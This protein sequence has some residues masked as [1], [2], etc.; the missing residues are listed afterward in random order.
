MIWIL[1]V[2]ALCH[3]L[4]RAWDVAPLRLLKEQLDHKEWAGFAFYDLIFPL[5]LFIIGVSLVFSL[6][7]ISEAGDRRAAVKRVLVRGALLYL[8]GLFY[9]GGFSRPWPELRLVGV[10]P[11]LAIGYTVAALLF[12]YFKPRTLAAITASLLLGYWALL[13]WV[14]VRDIALDK[15]AMIARFG[16]R[17]TPQQVGAAYDA[18]TATVT[19]RYEPGLNVANHFDFVHLPG[20]KYDVYWDPEGILSTIPAVA[21]CLLGVFAGLLLRRVDLD[22]RQKLARL[23]LAGALALAGGWAWHLEFPVVK[24]IWTSS[25]VLV[26]GGWSL[27]LLAAFYYAIDVRRWR[28]WAQPFVWIGMNAITLYVL[29]GAFGFFRIISQRLAGGDVKRWVDARLAAGAGDALL[30]AVGVGAVI[31]LAR[32]LHRRQLFLRL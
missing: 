2:D 17:V 22:E 28:G 27:L 5:F 32:F 1:G 19:G 11:R 25:F 20:G 8:L 26:A 31:L 16:P 21:T 6:K 23:A 29:S 14:P 24:K 3:A 4:A 9:A 18:T 10:L 13:A 30:A 12:C 15:H 7:R